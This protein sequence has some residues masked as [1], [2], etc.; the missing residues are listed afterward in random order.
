VLH[1]EAF[2][3]GGLADSVTMEPVTPSLSVTTRAVMGT[4]NELELAGI[5]NEVTVGGVV[6]IEGGGGGGGGGAGGGANSSEMVLIWAA[7]RVLRPDITG[8]VLIAVVI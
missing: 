4:V 3:E 6:S 1:P 8:L 7:A 2:A 5:L